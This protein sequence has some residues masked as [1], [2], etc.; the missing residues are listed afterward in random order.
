MLTPVEYRSVI[1]FFVLRG[2][3]QQF[4]IDEL[5]AAY[6]DDC[7]SK[8]TIYY[9]FKQFK[10]GRTNVDDD[11]KP[12]RPVEISDDKEA[13]LAQII[14]YERRLTKLELSIRLNVSIGHLQKLL[15]GMGVRK[16]CSR[17]VPYFISEELARKRLECC[18]YNLGLYEQLGDVFLSNIVTEDETPLSLFVPESKRDS[19]EWKFPGEVAT[20]K[21]K[22]GTSHRKSLMLSTFWDSRGIIHNDY[23]E[24][25][26]SMNGQYYSELVT[27]ARSKRRK[28]KLQD[29][30]FLHDNAPVHKSAVASSSLVKAGFF[31]L[32][33]PPYSSDLAP[34][35]FYL[36]KHL[37]KALA[38]RHFEKPDELQQATEDFFTQKPPDFFKKAFDDLV[39]RWQKCIENDGSYIEK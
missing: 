19:K 36:F 23:L 5:N 2:K 6:G 33:H 4:V 12:G 10:W 39:H 20:R 21:L 38:G 3:N 22:S 26:K 8:V 9:W 37:K 7:P 27:I 17:F 35:D 29:L 13:K 24:R 28:S 34:S 14:R 25:G 1:K 15:K 16:L 18:Q 32:E 11:E 30:Y 31:V